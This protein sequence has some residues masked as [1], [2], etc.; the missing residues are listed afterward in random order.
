MKRKPTEAQIAAARAKRA[1]L[2]ALSNKIRAAYDAEKFGQPR[3]AILEGCATINDGLR[4]IYRQQTG[5][6]DPD[7][8]NTFWGWKERGLLVRKGESGFA[9]WGEKKQFVKHEET[10]EGEEQEKTY[11]AFPIA[12]I[13]HAGQVEAK[14]TA[15]PTAAA[16]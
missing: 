3:P 5:Q 13:F 14:E 8:W 7:A 1:T 10:P 12:Y 16:A 2:A 4:A 15:Q 11:K 9:V 6:T